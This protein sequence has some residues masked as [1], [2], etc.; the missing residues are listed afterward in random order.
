MKYNSV[1]RHLDEQALVA[2]SEII[3]NPPEKE[4]YLQLKNLLIH[5]FTDLEKKKITA[6]ISGH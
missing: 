2:I 3:E 1:I 4:K 5:R 6:V